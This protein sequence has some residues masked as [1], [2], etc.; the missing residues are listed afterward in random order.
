[1]AGSILKRLKTEPTPLID[2]GTATFVWRGKSAPKLV[3]DFTGWEDGKPITLEKT[4]NG[5]WTWQITL[6]DDAYIE[7]TFLENNDSV[8]DPQNPR[9]TANGL[10][11][12]NNFFSMPGYEPTKL[13][14]P[15][16]GIERG[17]VTTHRLPTE[18]MVTGKERVVHLYHPPVEEPVALLVV[19]DGQDYLYRARLNVILDNLIALER[20]RP[21]A[22][23]FINHG[24]WRSRSIEYS[25]NEA[26]IGFLM[27]Q[28]MPLARANLKLINIKDQPGQFGVLGAS[29]SGLMALYTGLRLP[30][31][32]GHVLSQ[33]GAFAQGNFEMVV[34][35][36]IRHAEVRP[37]N[38][39]LDIGD[40]D[41]PGLL[42][43]NRRMKTTLDEH[44]YPLAYHEYHA[45]HNFTAWRDNLQQGLE[46]VYGL[47]NKENPA[48]FSR[49]KF[50]KGG[51]AFKG[52]IV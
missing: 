33:S 13:T 42:E 41:I 11:G 23:V 18:Y 50:P 37:I 44:G 47:G 40:Y 3:G 34:F 45:G 31:I 38:V 19:W 1:M 51:N 14:I 27:M 30:R 10:G 43:C 8:S 16:E 28:V 6:P 36:L 17:Y 48:G 22:A 52:S 5:I 12:Y 2:Q 29:M 39:W 25:C 9:Q 4:G 35:D 46:A 24:G 7:Y 20:I 26:T 21:L 32:F 49:I 15:R